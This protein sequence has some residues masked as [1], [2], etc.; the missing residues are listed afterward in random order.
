MLFSLLAGYYCSVFDT[1]LGTLKGFKATIRVAPAAQP[2]FCKSRSVPYA[3][4]EKI[5]KEL[6][7]LLKQGVIEK[8]NFSEWVASIFPVMKKDG[9][10]RMCG[11]N[12]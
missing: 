9:S 1:E 6:D 11:D 10:V 12:T 3:L 8:I 5:E 4:K 2:C 7:R